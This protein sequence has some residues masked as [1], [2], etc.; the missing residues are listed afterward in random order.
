MI[1][2]HVEVVEGPGGSKARIAG[3]RIRVQD[4]VIW[5][6]KLGLSPDEI[7]DQHPS[8]TLADVHSAL[9]Y[10]WDQRDE[11]EQAIAAEH[12]LVEK[13]R[14]ENLGPL[15]EKLKRHPSG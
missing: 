6:E 15:E 12:A 3:S 11:I 13:L 4:I 7:V 5:H 8:I 1:R 9:A 2:E 10:Y 14:D